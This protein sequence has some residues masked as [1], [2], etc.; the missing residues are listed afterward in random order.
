MTDLTDEFIPLDRTFSDLAPETGTDD[1]SA[2]TRMFGRETPL[3]WPELLDEHRVI[4]LSEAGSGKTAEIRAIAKSLRKEGKPAFFVRIENVVQSFEDAFEEGDFVEFETW[5]ASGSEGWLLLDSVDEARLADPKDFERAVRKLGRLLAPVLQQAHIVITGRTTAWRPKTD[6]LLCRTALPFDAAQTGTNAPGA[7]ADGPWPS[8][9]ETEEPHVRKKRSADSQTAPFRVVALDELGGTEIDA[10]LTGRNVTDKSALL[11][12]IERK[13]AW[14]FTTRPQDLAELVDFWTTHGRIGSRLE[15]M[16]NSVARRLEERDQGRSDARPIAA[17]RVREGA[18]LLAAATTLAQES[19]IRVPDGTENARGLPVREVLHDWDDRDCATL[20]GRPIFDEGIYGTVRFHHRSVREFLTAEWLH[21]LMVDEGSRVRIENLFFRTQYGLEVIVPTMRPVLPWLAIM[22]ERILQR[23]RR[24]E[25]EIVFEGGDPSQLPLDVRR[26]LLR[27]ACERLSLPAHSRTAT[28]NAAIQ[29]FANTDLT[30][31]IRALL[32]DYEQNDDILWFLLRMVWL[33]EIEGASGDVKRFALQARGRYV[34]IAAFRALL[35]VG[36][37]ADQAEVRAAFLVEDGAPRRDWTANL[38]PG[39]PLDAHGVAWVLAALERAPAKERYE[40]DGLTG[41]LGE[42]ISVLSIDQIPALVDGLKALLERP[43]VAERRRTALSE[44]YGWLISYAGQAVA[45]LIV[46]RNPAALGPSALSV[47]DKVPLARDDDNRDLSKVAANLPALVR[48]WPDLNNAL[49]WH[50]AAVTRL[51][52]AAKGERLIDFWNVSIFGHLWGFDAAGFDAVCDEILSRPDKDDRLVALTLAFALYREAGRPQAGRRRLKKIAASD[53]ELQSTLDGLLRPPRHGQSSWRRQ[54]AAWKRRDALDA[55]RSEK[56]RQDWRVF[57]EENIATLRTAP[58][59]GVWTNAQRYLHEQSRTFDDDSGKWSNGNWRALIPEFGDPI[60]T[61]YR[62]GAVAFWRQ[63][64]TALR[65]EGAPPNTTPF[66]AIFG[67]TGLAI[68]ARENPN[69]SSGLT[70]TEA[71]RASR[72]ALQELNGFPAWFP[73]LHATHPATV[74]KVV[75]REID[76]ELAKTPANIE[77]HYVLYDAA[78]SGDWM[79]D[80]LAPVLLQ[81]LRKPVPNL[82]NLRHML[83]IVQ[84]SSLADAVLAPLAASRAG[85]YNNLTSAPIWFAVWVGVEPA[86]AIPALAARLASL[87]RPADRTLFA[88]RFLTALIGGRGEGR[89]GR[90]AYRE[91][92]QLKALYLLMHGHIREGDDI[93]RMGKGV[94]SPGLRDEAQ[95]ARNALFSFIK[96]TPGKAAYVA[97]MDIAQAHPTE[98]SRP[99]MAFHARQKATS[100]ADARPWTPTEVRQF[101]DRLERT[102]GNH[103]DLWDLAIDR[104]HDLKHDLEQ[105]DSSIASILQPVNQ[106]T[107]IRKYIGNWCRERSAARYV[108]PQE[109]ELADAKRPDLRFHGVGFDG[110]VPAEL[111]LAD[112][113]TGPKLFERLEVQLCGDYLR[114]P[115]SSRGLFVLVYHGEKTGW[116]LPEGGHAASFEELVTALQRHW[117]GLASRIPWADDIRVIGIDLTLRGTSGKSRS[118][119]TASSAASDNMI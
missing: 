25:P 57:L 79:W 117:D 41:A 38:M 109:E 40:S 111:K 108:I 114:D 24:L 26:V 27:E 112:K 7:D 44:R 46:A 60:A 95:D 6:L 85:H 58:T 31:D 61:A 102:P 97:L 78:W 68:E 1:E 18:R 23:V 62:D 104:L 42:F 43:P 89:G 45:R 82:S 119:R 20:L 80:G 67:L 83:T 72:F 74:I 71:E 113:W 86:V 10:F 115:R 91:I 118:R 14:S 70:P 99:W 50:S 96:E 94:Y 39:V 103:R 110:P 33:G 81:R 66:G 100:D 77:S 69:W 51:R 36:A 64:Q 12:A 35:A 75:V 98:D 87:K 17:A 29:R 116:D 92:E 32:R 15:L 105:G 48:G 21:A 3:R 52:R 101:N 84:G 9:V 37:A 2:M 16:Q 5:A 73:A 76:H 22:D 11:E 4:L 19:A 93:D 88:M 63:H 30:D 107:E 34:R 53:P 90:Q 106:E 49:F 56:N 55:E 13:D 59:P 28:D 65:S 47:L 54:E 8:D